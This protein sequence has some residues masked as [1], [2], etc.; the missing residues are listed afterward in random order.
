MKRSSLGDVLGMVSG[1]ERILGAEDK[2]LLTVTVLLNP[3]IPIKPF[4]KQVLFLTSKE[5]EVFYGGTAGGGKSVAMLMAALQYVEAPGYSALILRRTYPE[6]TQEGGLITISHTWLD[7]TDAVW[8]EHK[9]RWEFPSGATLHFG[10]ME[11]EA[12]RERYQG[13]AYHFIG[14]DE[15]T[16]FTE[17]QYRFMFRSLRKDEDDWL[18]LRMRATGNPGGVGHQWVKERFIDGDKRFISSTWRE[19]PYLNREEY[20]KALNELDWVTRRRLKHGDWNV[21][22]EG[23]LFKKE[24]FKIEDEPKPIVQKVR[25]W[26]LAATPEKEGIDPD[27][28]V[29]ALLG[30]DA[31][32]E[33]WVLDIRRLRGTPMEVESAILQCAR[34]DGVGTAIR[35]EQEG[36]ASGKHVIDYYTRKLAGY[37]F[38][39]AR[40][41]TSKVERAKPLSAYAEAGKV[42]ILS[43]EW[44]Q[45]LLDELEAFP[46]AGIHDDQVDALTGAFQSL[47]TETARF[48][49]STL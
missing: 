13:S 19:N 27:W 11:T 40:V 8:K 37:N 35:I 44:T 23:G 24:W 48:S 36:G 39:G 17:T 4:Y 43:R 15:L 42:H 3:Y 28:T 9:K 25:F 14:F 21:T 1:H 10:H 34:L 12:D 22:P 7:D 31:D 2:A 30:L 38:R 45:T 41:Q 18:P 49:I 6:L 29:G 20:E 46:T 5:R 16:Q 32:G 47:F 26:D 33:V